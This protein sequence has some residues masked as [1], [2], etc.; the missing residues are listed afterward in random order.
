MGIKELRQV[1]G[2]DPRKPR[3]AQII[4]IIGNV[5]FDG[6]FFLKMGDSGGWRL[7]RSSVGAEKDSSTWEANGRGAM[8]VL[9]ASRCMGSGLSRQ[10]SLQLY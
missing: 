6:V 1:F 2:L 5:R 3:T 4:L 8:Y 7:S 9:P 10:Q